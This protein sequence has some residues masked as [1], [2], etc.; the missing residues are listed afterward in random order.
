MS[1]SLKFIGLSLAVAAA[2]DTFK[3]GSTAQQ[4]FDD[5]KPG[6][7]AL[8]KQ[9]SPTT[10][11]EVEANGS[12]TKNQKGEITHS[13]FSCAIKPVWGSVVTEVPKAASLETPAGAGCCGG[14]QSGLPAPFNTASGSSDP[15]APRAASTTNGDPDPC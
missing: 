13:S 4:E 2:I 7:L 9:N 1:W 14:K 6:L 12:Q 10:T 11:L 5:I 15:E 3:P 8:V